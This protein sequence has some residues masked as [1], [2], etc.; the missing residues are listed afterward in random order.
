M[1]TDTC[2]NTD[3]STTSRYTVASPSEL[4]D[5]VTV[6]P[7]PSTEIPLCDDFTTVDITPE[8]FAHFL[9]SF[10]C[11]GVKGT[12]DVSG[13]VQDLSS[14]SSPSSSSLYDSMTLLPPSTTSPL[15]VGS[16]EPETPSNTF[17]DTVLN[18]TGYYQD[19]HEQQHNNHEN[20]ANVSSFDPYLHPPSTTS[21]PLPQSPELDLGTLYDTSTD[22]ADSYLSAGAG[23]WTYPT[24]YDD[25]HTA[26]SVPALGGGGYTSGSVGTNM[27][28]SEDAPFATT[29]GGPGQ[30]TTVVDSEKKRKRD[31]VVEEADV[32]NSKR[33]RG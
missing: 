25:V 20:I 24:L 19:H 14:P 18:T 8:Q 1:H 28:S 27:L 22:N 7:Q 23:L 6:T 4:G 30:T 12:N 33:G 26:D 11:T 10:P 3:T 5:N 17:N 16:G 13:V 31:Q 9:S 29:L 32:G 21:F 15:G 2:I